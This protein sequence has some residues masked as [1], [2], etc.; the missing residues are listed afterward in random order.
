MK[1]N[2]IYL[3]T[4][5]PKV[6]FSCGSKFWNK[7][8]GD[9]KQKSYLITHPMWYFSFSSLPHFWK[10]KK[11][12]KSKNID[13]ILFNNSK[14]EHLFAKIFGFKSYHIN[15]NLN[16]NEHIF[17]PLRLEKKFDCVYTAQAK[18]FK[19]IHLAEKIKSLFIITFCGGEHRNP[20][21]SYNI[22]MYEPKV[23]HAKCNET[24]IDSE[25]VNLILNQSRCGLALSAKEGAMLAFVEYLLAGIPV[26]TTKSKGGRDHYI[27]KSFVK[28]VKADPNEVK[29]G[30]D[31]L[32]QRDISPEFIREKT[33][34]LIYIERKK[35]FNVIQKITQFEQSFVDFSN[36]M[37]G[38]NNSINQFIY[39]EKKDD[40]Q[41]I[42]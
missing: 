33:L 28:I 34:E 42:K 22:G 30:V 4:N 2:S 7:L 38:N 27:N 6:Y 16:V 32:I 13:L 19:R 20:N 14:E 26:V 35:F 41:I 18:P 1:F 8:E 5:K 9:S 23:N 40:Y 11:M 37:W 17:K 25:K 10:M 36:R 12:L 29:K 39:F 3:L 24:R 21:G 15:Q 31:E